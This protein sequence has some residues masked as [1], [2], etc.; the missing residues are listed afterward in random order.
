MYKGAVF[1]LF[2]FHSGA[3]A[4]AHIADAIKAI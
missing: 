1:D 4:M 3:L 2:F